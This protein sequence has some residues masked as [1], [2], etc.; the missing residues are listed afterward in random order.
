MRPL[1]VA[2]ALACLHSGAAQIAV[3]VQI[4]PD[5]SL[6]PVSL[7]PTA[8]GNI[9]ASQGIAGFSGVLS[10]TVDTQLVAERCPKGTYSSLQ[11]VNQVSSQVCVS[12]PAGTASDVDGASDPS[13]CSPCA[14]GSYALSGASACTDCPANTFS[15]TPQAPGPSSCI[16][17]PLNTTSPARSDSIDKC[18]CNGGYFASQNLLNALPYAAV[19]LALPFTNAAPIDYAHVTC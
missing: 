19:P 6:P 5:P 7:D 18:V 13:T 12:C 3:E 1:F 10:Q 16:A 8:L 15:V 11:T 2:L 14:T 17:C 9:A 4:L